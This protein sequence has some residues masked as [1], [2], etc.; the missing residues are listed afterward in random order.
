MA[1]AEN[2]GGGGRLYEMEYVAAAISSI[3]SASA[4][5]IT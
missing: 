3:V 5:D 1:A 2:R 4:S